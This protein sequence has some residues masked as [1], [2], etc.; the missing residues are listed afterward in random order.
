MIVE[1]T[2]EPTATPTRGTAAPTGCAVEAPSPRIA[3][4]TFGAGAGT[5]LVALTAASDQGGRSGTFD[6]N[7]VLSVPGPTVGCAFERD[8]ALVVYLDAASTVAVDAIVSLVA[9]SVKAAPGFLCWPYAPASSGKVGAPEDG[10]APAA[11]LGAETG[12]FVRRFPRYL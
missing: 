12:S 11:A 6:C 9:R 5:L 7:D 3:G 1:P 10:M 2:I 4:V 8:D